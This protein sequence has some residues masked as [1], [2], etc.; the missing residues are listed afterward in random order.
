MKQKV[1]NKSFYNTEKVFLYILVA[2]LGLSHIIYNNTDKHPQENAQNKKH[3][4]VYEIT[5]YIPEPP[6]M[7]EWKN[8]YSNYNKQKSCLIRNVFYEGP[9]YFNGMEDKSVYK[10]YNKI[11]LLEHIVKERIK[12]VNVTMNRVESDLY[13]DSLCEVIYQ[14]KQFSWTLQKDK[15]WANL[16]SKYRYNSTELAN[17][18]DIERLVDYAMRYQFEDITNGALYYHTHWVSPYWKSSK[19]HLVSSLWHKY[20]NNGYN[21]MDKS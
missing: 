20:Y 8:K 4:L 1:K 14:Y 11:Q 7:P 9:R 12:I 13:P 3:E 18:E 10:D 15:K 19:T 17:I 16:K 5:E 2:V 6:K 21:N